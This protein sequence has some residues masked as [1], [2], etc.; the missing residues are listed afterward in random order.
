M[1]QKKTYLREKIGFRT[2]PESSQR[3]KKR[4]DF[5]DKKKTPEVFEVIFFEIQFKKEKKVPPL[6]KK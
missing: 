2:G 3:K 1:M 6:S 4:M 5:H